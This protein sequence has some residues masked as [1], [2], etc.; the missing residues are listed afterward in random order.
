MK[1]ATAGENPEKA[2]TITKVN[3]GESVARGERAQRKKGKTTKQG[4]SGDRVF[5]GTYTS[6]RNRRQGSAA[7]GKGR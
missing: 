7:Y 1:V 2:V 3:M 6:P 4:D 5:E